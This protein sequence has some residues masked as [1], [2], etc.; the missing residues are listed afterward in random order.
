MGGRLLDLLLA[1]L[2]A[3]IAAGVVELGRKK[4]KVEKWR[5]FL[6]HSARVASYLLVGYYVLLMVL[7]APE[8]L[9]LS[10]ANYEGEELVVRT[11]HPFGFQRERVVAFVVSPVGWQNSHINVRKGERISFSAHGMVNIAAGE[12]L[13]TVQ[14]RLRIENQHKLAG[15][16]PES[17]SQKELAS[18]DLRYGLDW[19]GPAG[20]PGKYRSVTSP[21]SERLLAGHSAEFGAL[22]GAVT[23]ERA[24]PNLPDS[25]VF[26]IGAERPWMSV[27]HDGELWFN[28]NDLGFFPDSPSDQMGRWYRDNIGFFTVV[29]TI[30]D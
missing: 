29:V 15:M 17:L 6:L 5:D 26:R 9:T 19:V 20:F 12:L 18:I 27:P 16:P 21:G 1:F 14:A 24:E 10:S 2:F 7:I 30:L 28:V 4:G 22:M 11:I 25:V 3:F 8:F 23:Y 13:Q